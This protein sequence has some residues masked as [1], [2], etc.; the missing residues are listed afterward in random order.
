MQNE[1]CV[2]CSTV[3]GVGRAN[4]GLGR[5]KAGQAQAQ[6]KTGP[7]QGRPMPRTRQAQGRAF[8][9]QGEG[10]TAAGQVHME[11]DEARDD[12]RPVDVVD[13]DAPPERFERAEL[14]F[15]E[16]RR[17]REDGRAAQDHVL[18]Q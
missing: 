5:S 7:G 17:H 14:R 18:R 16:R 6:D 9:A 3:A 8:A 1:R 4:A 12:E 2:S 10:R 15:G 13:G 11:V